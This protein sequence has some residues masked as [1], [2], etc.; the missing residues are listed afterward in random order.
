MSEL[1][2]FLNMSG[3]GHFIWSAFGISAIILLGILVQSQRF[4]K[5]TEK[6]LEALNNQVVISDTVN[7][8]K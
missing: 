1:F 8:F 3:Y 5:R 7:K 2:T 4:L 6:E